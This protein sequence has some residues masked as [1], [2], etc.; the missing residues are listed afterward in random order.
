M[1]IFHCIAYSITININ[2][3]TLYPIILISDDSKP[4]SPPV[5]NILFEVKTYCIG[6]SSIL[7]SV[8]R[9]TDHK[10]DDQPIQYVLTS[11]NML[12]T[13]GEFGFESSLISIIGY[14][15][16]ILILIVIE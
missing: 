8:I 10:I 3:I 15:V 6:W 11:N 12:I 4:N 5:I 13:G 7:W 14:S 16:I 1:I 9:I 2:I